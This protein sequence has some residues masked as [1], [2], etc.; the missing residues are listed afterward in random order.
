M[1]TDM[2]VYGP[3]EVG[4]ESSGAIKRVEGEHRS[5]FWARREVA[6][7]R[8]KQGCYVFAIRAGKGFTPWY[9]GRASK[10]FEQEIFAPHKLG[11]YNRALF[12][13]SKGTPVMFFVAPQGSKKKVNTKALEQME[14]ELIQFALKRNPHIC[15]VQGTKNLPQWSIKGVVRSSPGKPDAASR[16]FRTM[17]RM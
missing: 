13:G 10:G 5:E 3:F 14:K 15:N 6:H 8:K 16:S 12:R 4:F 1:A 9:V 11:H 7:L 17:M 2:C